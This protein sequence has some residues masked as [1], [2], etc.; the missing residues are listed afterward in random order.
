M[1]KL[2]S[3]LRG[4]L[5]VLSA[6]AILGTAGVTAMPA[7]A[8]GFSDALHSVIKAQSRDDRSRDRSRERDTR[9]RDRNRDRNTRNRD[10][11]RSHDHSRDRNRSHD[12]RS[13]RNRRNRNS[14]NRSSRDNRSYGRISNRHDS[15]NRTRN[16]HS[17]YSYRHRDSYNA[18]RGWNSARY[19]SPWS[20]YTGRH[21]YR[22]NYRSGLGISFSFGSPG[23]SRYRW[24]PSRHSFYQPSFGSYS[25]YTRR[26]TC[27]PILV[28]AY[29]HGHIETVEV[30]QCSNPWD[31]TY[32]IQGSERIVNCFY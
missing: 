20:S 2:S 23:Y 14:Y 7:Y 27:R 16:R 1:T 18:P 25:H 6:T 31:G 17:V 4:A 21:K 12:H 10:R 29:H 8:S 11:D 24:A 9:S 13:D 19:S 30:T 15:R 28:D 32:I 22:T 5:R 26:T 3:P